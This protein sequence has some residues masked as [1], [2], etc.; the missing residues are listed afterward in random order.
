MTAEN[1]GIWRTIRPPFTR[2][3]TSVHFH[4]DADG[5]AYVCDYARCD[6]P[7]LTLKEASLTDTGARRRTA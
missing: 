1:K 4:I 7:A 3:R 5:R 2:G 6:S